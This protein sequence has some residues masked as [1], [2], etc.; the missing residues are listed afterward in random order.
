[1]LICLAPTVI[2]R[3]YNSFNVLKYQYELLLLEKASIQKQIDR[4]N[5]EDLNKSIEFIS[6]NNTENLTLPISDIAFIKSADNYVEIVFTENNV[7]K[8]KLIRTTLKN[9]ELQIK[10][11]SI[12]IRCHRICIVN[13]NFIVKLSKSFGSNRINIKGYNEQIPVSRQYLLK[14]KEVL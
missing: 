9:I 11:F 10:P 3:V 14:L 13:R 5:E 6:E 7:F 4:I 2:I 12:F 8:K 1:M